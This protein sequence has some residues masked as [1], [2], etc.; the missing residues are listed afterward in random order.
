MLFIKKI[1]FVSTSSVVRFVY[2]WSFGSYSIC[3]HNLPKLNRS[4]TKQTQNFCLFFV[5]LV[6]LFNQTKCV[7]F[8]FCTVLSILF[9]T[10]QQASRLNTSENNERDVTIHTTCWFYNWQ[11]IERF[12]L[13]KTLFRHKIHNDEQSGTTTPQLITNK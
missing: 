7:I 12:R 4:A 11:A 1:I 2:F 10:S 5:F 9:A 6:R 3:F 13:K 8:V